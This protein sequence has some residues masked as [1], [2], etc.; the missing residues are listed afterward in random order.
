MDM[1]HKCRVLHEDHHFNINVSILLSVISYN[2]PACAK[3]LLSVVCHKIK[4]NLFLSGVQL[5]VISHLNIPIWTL[6]Y[7]HVVYIR[8]RMVTFQSRCHPGSIHQKH[9]CTIARHTLVSLP[10][11]TNDRFAILANMFILQ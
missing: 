6:C 11:C 8:F 1:E 10:K 4:W 3:P 2:K 7:L 9:E 5:S